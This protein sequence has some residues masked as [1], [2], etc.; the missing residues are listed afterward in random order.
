MHDLPV[1]FGLLV[2]L[3]IW[4]GATALCAIPGFVLLAINVASASLAIGMASARSRDIPRI[5][6]SLVQVLFL[7]TPII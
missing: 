1:Y 3:Q 6:A 2:Y 4:P 5:I 7:I